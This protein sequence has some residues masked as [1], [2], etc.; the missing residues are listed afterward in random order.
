MTAIDIDQFPTKVDQLSPRYRE[1]HAAADGLLGHLPVA[2][3]VLDNPDAVSR[4]TDFD[5][6]LPNRLDHNFPIEIAVAAQK[7][8]RGQAYQADRYDPEVYQEDVAQFV[9]PIAATGPGSR[10]AHLV[11]RM[12]NTFFATILQHSVLAQR[13]NSEAAEEDALAERPLEVSPGFLILQRSD[14]FPVSSPAGEALEMEVSQL[15]MDGRITVSGSERLFSQ[16]DIATAVTAYRPGKPRADASYSIS[17][18]QE[19]CRTSISRPDDYVSVVNGL[20]EGGGSREDALAIIASSK[21][22]A[23]SARQLTQALHSIA[24]QQAGR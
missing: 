20:G 24:Q 4:A 2:V 15:A 3:T 12:Q 21:L 8:L 17:S 23:L 5:M 6:D 18:I 16:A 11:K 14:R 10:S 13:V 22:L 7:R 19:K 9:A 1:L